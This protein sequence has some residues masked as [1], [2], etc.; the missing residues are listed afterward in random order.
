MIIN[1]TAAKT[2]IL[3]ELNLLLF[4]S[5]NQQLNFYTCNYIRPL[6][7]NNVIRLEERRLKMFSYMA[8][9]KTRYLLYR[10]S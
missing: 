6:S 9:R 4:G 8:L 5:H 10:E 7:R 1:N 2:I 3:V